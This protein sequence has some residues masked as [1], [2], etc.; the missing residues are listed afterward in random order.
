MAA[1]IQKAIDFAEVAHKGQTYG[2]HLSYMTHLHAVASVVSEFGFHDEILITA[3]YLHDIIEDTKHNYSDIDKEFGT[4]VAEIVYHVTDELGRN[5]KERHAKTYPK[6]ATKPE[7]IIIKL[8]DRIANTRASL[9]S[10]DTK[11]EMYKKEYPYFRQVL[12]NNNSLTEKMW[13]ELDRIYGLP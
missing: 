10:K 5:R 12:W 13:A 8:A 1:L 11:F 9:H 3:A 4:K 7:A 2:E 6:I